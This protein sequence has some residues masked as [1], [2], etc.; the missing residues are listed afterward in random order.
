MPPRR[1]PALMVRTEKR[2][3]FVPYQDPDIGAAFSFDTVLS[4]P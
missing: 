4:I 1:S 3:L 2:D